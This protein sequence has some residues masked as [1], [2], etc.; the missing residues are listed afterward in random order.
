MRLRYGILALVALFPLPLAA[1]G[2]P[3]AVLGEQ[4]ATA[5]FPSPHGSSK[6]PD[7]FLIQAA[8]GG[9]VY[10]IVNGKKSRILAAIF[11]RWVKE[12]HYFKADAAARLSADELQDYP[13]APPHNTYYWGKILTAGDTRYYI[14]DRYRKR[15]IAP[16]VQ[17]AL[18]YP[19]SNV[20]QVPLSFLAAFPDGPAITQTDR[21]PGGTVMY[22]GPYHGGKLYLIRNDDTKHEFLSDYVYEAMG[23]NW[24]SQI[25]PVSAEELTRYQRGVHL[26][27]YPDGIIMGIAGKKY[28]VQEGRIRWI[29]SEAIFE[30]L[31]YNPKYVFTVLPQLNKN[32]G[33]GEPVTAF[34]SIRVATAEG[35][36]PAKSAAGAEKP[37]AGALSTLPASKQA[38]M[39]KVNSIFLQV[40]DRNPTPAENR[41]WIAY[42]N[43]FN[44]G[45]ESALA[46]AMTARK[47][48]SK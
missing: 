26:S 19:A 24:S 34:K 38:L 14:D 18:K 31:G 6:L 4:T 28:L 15:P 32:Y 25:L 22:F 5:R 17:A 9:D 1:G 44:P 45:S 27:T 8:D 47:G 11:D 21:H 20:Y 40:Y 12:M 41:Y 48:R 2:G 13:E 23:F 39:R 46:K 42:I 36:N 29:A 35:T 30:A 10:Q 16:A 33:A 43:D 3:G 7:G 37:L